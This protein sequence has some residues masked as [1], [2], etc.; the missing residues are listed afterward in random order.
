RADTPKTAPGDPRW[1]HNAPRA[2]TAGK[3]ETGGKGAP[4]VFRN[5]AGWVISPTDL[6]D[7]MECDHRSALKTA[8]AAKLPGAPAPADIDPLV[9]QHGHEHERA[10]LD[11]LRALFGEDGVAAIDD[12][13]PTHTDMLRAAQATTRA[14]ADG[15]PVIYQGV[16]YHRLADGIAFHG[17]AD[18]LIST[19]VDPATG[20]PV[21]G[22]DPRRYE[23]HDTK[24]ARRPGPSAVLQL[25]AY[26]RA[27]PDTG[28]PAPE[29]MHLITG[30]GTTHTHRAA[31][32]TPLLHTL[33][34]RLTTRLTTPQGRPL[35]TGDLH[36]PAPLWGEPRPAC[37]GCGYAA[38][39]RSEER[40]VGEERRSG[41][42]PTHGEQRDAQPS[43]AL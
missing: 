10:E 16:F 37:D 21:P 30:D 17:R 29:H 5:E 6:V 28:A 38:L 26:A 23:P 36:L 18:F 35:D 4:H 11:R 7:A 40:R 25:S 20:R 24:L 19:A 1:W 12:P 31:E 42:R 15:T 27:L 3:T 9:A 14:M 34:R 32:F 33:T 39:C 22:A 8:L 43:G 2:A 41:E 13:H